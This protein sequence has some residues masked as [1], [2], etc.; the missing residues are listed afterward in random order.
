[1]SYMN[2][3]HNRASTLYTHASQKRRLTHKKCANGKALL[4]FA[5]MRTV[6]FCKS[7]RSVEIKQPSRNAA[8]DTTR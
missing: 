1:M 5:R 6:N 8:V 3:R 4:S 7:P 2:V